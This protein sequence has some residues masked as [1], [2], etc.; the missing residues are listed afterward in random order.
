MEERDLGLV[1]CLRKKM[2]AKSW[3][4]DLQRLMSDSI[5]SMRR[6]M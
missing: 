5:E 3:T 6:I 1:E 2:D 4:N